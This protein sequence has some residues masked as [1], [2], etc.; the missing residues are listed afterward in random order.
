MKFFGSS[1]DIRDNLKVAFFGKILSNMSWHL[2]QKRIAPLLYLVINM[3]DW[4]SRVFVEI[5]VSLSNSSRERSINSTERQAQGASA[6]CNKNF[7]GRSQL[8]TFGQC[9]IYWEAGPQTS[10][11]VSC[12]DSAPTV[13]QLHRL[14]NSIKSE[15]VTRFILGLVDF[16][17]KKATFKL[18]LMSNDENKFLPIFQILHI[19]NV[20]F[21]LK[22]A[23][24]LV[25]SI[26][27][28][29]APVWNMSPYQHFWLTQ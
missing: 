23:M 14:D 27:M 5:A 17:P 8:N 6:T 24:A 2:P 12:T 22:L 11:Q 10:A 29:F 19:N 20:W 26:V 7:T 25:T 3:T 28:K 13:I 9:Q 1:L 16:F 15:P 4:L 18:S 21:L